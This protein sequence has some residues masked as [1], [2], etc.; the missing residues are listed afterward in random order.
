[1]EEPQQLLEREAQ[2][3]L[4]PQECQDQVRDERDPNLGHDRV[5]RGSP[6]G[7]EPQVLFDDLQEQLD[8]PPFF[9]DGRN[10]RGGQMQ[11]IGPEHLVVAGF[12]V[13]VP[14]SPPCLGVGSAM[15]P[16]QDDVLV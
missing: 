7:L 2:A 12:G 14:H 15:W 9:V 13:T 6:E 5:L 10:R 1:L 8:L 11:G 16:L 4:E 3:A